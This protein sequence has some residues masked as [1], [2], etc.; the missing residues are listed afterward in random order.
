MHEPTKTTAVMRPASEVATDIVH[1]AASFGTYLPTSSSSSVQ[2]KKLFFPKPF[3]LFPVTA[4]S[5]CLQ[6]GWAGKGAKELQIAGLKWQ[7]VGS[8]PPKKG[9]EIQNEN[10]AEALRNK[11]INFTVTDLTE[12]NMTNLCFDNYILGFLVFQACC[13]DAC[14]RFQQI[15]K[16]NPP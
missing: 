13:A 16:K 7:D 8:K 3:N 5:F 9:A 2:Q 4:N 1:S 11:Q 15:S 14:E 6:E 12:L 10:L